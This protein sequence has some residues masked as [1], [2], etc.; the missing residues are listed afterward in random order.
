MST[1]LNPP[2]QNLDAVERSVTPSVTACGSLLVQQHSS[3]WKK[4]RTSLSDAG[5]FGYL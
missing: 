2:V 3:P 1:E 5:S 4:I